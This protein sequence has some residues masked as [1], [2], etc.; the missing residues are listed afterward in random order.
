MN[1]SHTPFPVEEHKRLA[2]HVRHAAIAIG[3][4]LGRFIDPQ[5]VLD[6]GCGTGT[7]LRALSDAGR[8]EVFGIEMDPGN[9]A[10]LE[11]PADRILAADLGQKLDLHRRFDLVLCLEVAEHLDAQFADMVVENCV[12]H[13]DIILFSAALP[14]QQ[15]IHHVNEQLPQ[16]WAARFAAHDYAVFD[17]IRPLIWD[18]PQIPVWYRQNVLLF[19]RAGAAGA[20]KLW[21]QR[22]TT[23][24][25]SVVTDASV[26]PSP[27]AIAHPDYL[28]LFSAR[29]N[30]AVTEAD[31]LRQRWR[32][33]QTEF[34]A[35]LAEAVHRRE[36]AEAALAEAIRC[37]DA[38]AKAAAT[39]EAHAAAAAARADAANT[40]QAAH[41]AA[42]AKVE[43]A[44]QEAKSALA[45]EKAARQSAQR[46]HDR[47]AHDLQQAR[48]EI[49]NLWWERRVIFNSTGWRLTEPLRALGRRLPRGL[50]ARLRAAIARDRKG[51]R[52]FS[53]PG[54]PAAALSHALN[55]EPVP[56]M[57]PALSPVAQIVPREPAVTHERQRIVF[58]SGEP[59]IPG[60]IYRVR[61]TMDAALALGAE[62][63]LLPLRDVVARGETIARADIMVIWRAQNGPE[64]SH[65]LWVARQHGIKVLFDV[66]DLMFDPKF[67]SRRVIDGIRSLDLTEDEIAGH[68]QSMKEVIVKADVCTCTTE[69]LARHLRA[70]DCITHVLPNVFD[71]AALRRSRLAVRQRVAADDGAAEGAVAADGIVRIGY[72]AGTRTHQRDF[73]PA[74]Q[75]LER[76]LVERPQC[77]LVLFRDAATGRPLLDVAEFPGLAQL[78]D[79]IEWRDSVPLAEL[80]DELA[81]FDINLAPLEV[82]NPFCEAKSELKFFE[83]ALV[84]VCTIA[85][86]TGP[87]RRAIRDKATGRLADTAQEWYDAMLELVDDPAQRRR[88]AH[89]AYLDV[90]VQ[91]GPQA[92]IEALQSVLAQLSGD[93]AAARAFQFTL[94]RQQTWVPPAF[95]IP[96]SSVV[97]RSDR[98]GDADVTVILPLF[99]YAQFIE[100]ALDSVHAQTLAQIDL[101]VVDD[102]STD[103]S[104]SVAV[105]WARRHA[106]RFGRLL[107][108]NNGKNAGL[109]RARNVGFDAAETPFVLPLDA[110]NRLRPDCCAALLATLHASRAAFA[111]SHL[112]C[113]GDAAHIIGIEPFSPLRFASSNYIDAMALVAKWAWASV[114]G[115]SHIAH[116]WE[117]YDFW[118]KCVENGLWGRQVPQILAEYRIHARS[119]LRTSTD[120]AH[121]KRAVIRQLKERHPWMTIDFRP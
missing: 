41:F 21:A 40:A 115:F 24:S 76:I 91:F 42:L 55:P 3:N 106:A 95:D 113:F 13:G 72:A 100:E 105:A 28:H 17:L 38:A 58:I 7:W 39:A 52:D 65:A 90:L 73:H 80:P 121:N 81:R 14:G 22:D 109:A 36:R 47:L 56:A 64:V 59:H 2:A 29:A 30:A 99:N 88:L 68:F 61:R 120:R 5:S 107:V 103:N 44:S 6:L 57:A 63:D 85:S 23:R 94:L 77:R 69:E 82:G 37:A 114:G 20:D 33:A 48:N 74:A 45:L 87:Q 12:R 62:V 15:G 50:R 75:A 116:G 86:P 110:D 97:F 89:A 67:A 43:L 49:A 46:Q 60:H 112:Q 70:F 71:A 54:Q 96:N 92:G 32:R 117:D 102:V 66:D 8:R 35:A 9:P 16:Y 111:Y 101:V 11:V 31:A 53:P 26:H 93:E 118:C 104:L 108:L 51:K 83:A 10:D 1:E 19:A 25:G 34:E 27:L 98:L 4:I 78:G 84:E 119:M 18:D 79:R